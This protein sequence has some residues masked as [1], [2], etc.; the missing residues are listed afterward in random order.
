MAGRVEGKIALITGA[1][2]GQGRSHAKLLAEEGADI[3]AIDALSNFETVPY[4][5]STQKDL[6][7]TVREVEATGRRIYAAQADIADFDGLKKAVDDGVNELGGLD[8][9]SSHAGILSFSPLIE[10]SEQKWQEMID[11]NLSGHWRTAKAT[12]PHLINRGSGSITFTIS[13]AGLQGMENI[14]HYASAKHGVVGLMRTLA[15]ELGPH[16]IRVN[17]IHPTNLNS[18]MLQNEAAYKTFRPDLENPNFEEFKEA[19]ADMHLLP[20]VALLEPIDTSRMLLFL[21]SDDARYITGSKM[22]VD[23]GALTK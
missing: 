2:R 13:I 8:I 6:D 20:N 4:D 7:E 12:A 22:V 23:A 9:V 19:S 16:N 14:G 11:I 18:P 17:S 15:I 5:E 21:S 1:A 10:M 3:I